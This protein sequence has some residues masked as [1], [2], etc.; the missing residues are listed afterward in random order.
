M[1][2]FTEDLVNKGVYV[3]MRVNGTTPEG[4]PNYAYVAI[5]ASQM[6][7]FAAAIKEGSIRLEDYVTVL[8]AGEGE[9]SEEEARAIEE[10]Y[11][12]NPMYL[13][14]LLEAIAHV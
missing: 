12:M 3:T 10:K 2:G 13:E 6:D 5:Q 8:H 1:T 9:P 4:K 11:G 7:A 14:E